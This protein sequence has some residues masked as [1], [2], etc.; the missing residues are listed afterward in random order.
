MKYKVL[1]PWEIFWKK[2]FD[3]ILSN[4]LEPYDA[5]FYVIFTPNVYHLTNKKLQRFLTDTIAKSY[6]IVVPEYAE[7]ALFY[8]LRIY[9]LYA[10]FYTLPARNG[11]GLEI[12][13]SLIMNDYRNSHKEY[14]FEEAFAHEV[15][16]ASM[17]ITSRSW[18]IIHSILMNQ[19][20]EKVKR[21]LEKSLKE[22]Q[23]EEEKPAIRLGVFYG[24]E[25]PDEFLNSAL[26]KWGA[27]ADEK[28]MLEQ[29]GGRIEGEKLIFPSKALPYLYAVLLYAEHALSD[30]DEIIQQYNL[31]ME[32]FKQ[33]ENQYKGD[34]KIMA[35]KI[36]DLQEKLT[37]AQNK[38]E[39]VYV[40]RVANAD[41][42]RKEIEAE[43]ESVISSLKNEVE[44]WKQIASQASASVRLDEVLALPELTT[45]Q[46]FGLPNPALFAYLLKYNI[47]VKRFSPIDPPAAVGN[48]PIVFNIDVATHKVWEIIKSKK[49]LI[50]TGSNKEIL[51]RKIV[52]WLN[53][54]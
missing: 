53:G 12:L 10:G 42:I 18:Y 21:L 29:L 34:T 33:F 52:E 50:I 4:K 16:M 37:I 22:E 25:N 23:K 1:E 35:D 31:L 47:D 44:E 54:E 9:D 41:E 45:I 2:V 46:Y 43:Y 32:K 26:K 27:N 40:D 51:A 3:Y 30:K 8:V 14:T 24:N 13:Y 20:V 28:T 49:P 17:E 19:D 6:D 38:K 11:D 7:L 5:L 36:A 15:D 39:V 48:S